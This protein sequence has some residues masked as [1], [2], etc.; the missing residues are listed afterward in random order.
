MCI[1]SCGKHGLDVVLDITEDHTESLWCA[2]LGGDWL[3]LDA[4]YERLLNSA[5]SVL[6][7]CGERS[8]VDAS[9]CC[10]GVA[11]HDEARCGLSKLCLSSGD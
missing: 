5:R 3:D 10:L 11:R 6:E 7:D 8:L 4:L 2:W 1:G 9:C